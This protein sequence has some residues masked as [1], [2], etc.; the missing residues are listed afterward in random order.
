MITCDALCAHSHG[1][2]ASHARPDCNCRLESGSAPGE[3]LR[4]NCETMHITIRLSCCGAAVNWCTMLASKARI[5][6][7]SF[8]SEHS[9]NSQ[10]PPRIPNWQKQNLWPETHTRCASA[11]VR[12]GQATAA[13]SVGWPWTALKLCWQGAAAR[14]HKGEAETRRTDVTQGSESVAHNGRQEKAHL[15]PHRTKRTS[16]HTMPCTHTCLT[17]SLAAAAQRP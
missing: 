15:L 11:I 6:L 3:C 10:L 1:A 7:Q 17:S 14:G 12:G 16:C 9:T 5:Q 2:G 13:A 4:G 8:C